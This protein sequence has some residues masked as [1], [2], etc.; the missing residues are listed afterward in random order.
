[1]RPIITFFKSYFL[2]L[3]LSVVAFFSWVE[4][5]ELG[6]RFMSESGTYQ[7]ELPMDR[8]ETIGTSVSIA[9]GFTGGALAMGLIAC[10][11]IVMIVWIE[12]KKEKQS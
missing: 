4:S 6:H 8:Y 10:V 5:R 11:C 1:M 2:Q 9:S 7:K 3:L 12:I